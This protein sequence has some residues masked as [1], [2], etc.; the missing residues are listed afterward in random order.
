MEIG[1]DDD[2]VTDIDDS[3]SEHD[4]SSSSE[5]ATAEDELNTAEYFGLMAA[6]ARQNF[7]QAENSNNTAETLQK[8]DR[9]KT[10]ITPRTDN[11]NTA[12]ENNQP[13]DAQIER[14]KVCAVC[15]DTSAYRKHYNVFSC[16]GK[17]FLLNRKTFLKV[18]LDDE[19]KLFK[20][21]KNFFTIL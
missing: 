6:A 7:L 2:F 8:T 17:F 14:T 18:L 3:V 15:G 13:M 9:E 16:E 11:N 20:A 12:A 5:D 21:A 4:T 1:N 10:Q 19:Q